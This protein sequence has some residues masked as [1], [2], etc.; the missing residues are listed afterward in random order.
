MSNKLPFQSKK[1]DIQSRVNGFGQYKQIRIFGDDGFPSVNIDFGHNHGQ[2]NPHFHIWN[3][4]PGGCRPT[5]RNRLRGQPL[6]EGLSEILT[7]SKGVGKYHDA[8]LLKIQESNEK[9]ILTI[10][11][12]RGNRFDLSIT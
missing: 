5:N 4:P 7:P 2:G 8:R 9:F 1:Y 11:D 12:I 6:N 3:R 10:D